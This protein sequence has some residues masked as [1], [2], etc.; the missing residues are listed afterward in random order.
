MK[1]RPLMLC[2]NNFW[3]RIV[4]RI[5]SAIKIAAVVV[6][7]SKILMARQIAISKQIK[8]IDRRLCFAM[9]CTWRIES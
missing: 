7:A 4:E 6:R 3:F 9:R 5:L 1:M 8:D 2:W